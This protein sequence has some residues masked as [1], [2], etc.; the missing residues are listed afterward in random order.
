MERL[1]KG[2]R[3]TYVPIYGTA[4]AWT[5][6]ANGSF[7]GVV[8]GAWLFIVLFLILSIAIVPILSLAAF[9]IYR[10]HSFSAI[11]ALP[12]ACFGGLFYLFIDQIFF[13]ETIEI[14]ASHV[15][16]RRK[17]LLTRTL[18]WTEPRTH[19]LGV[20]KDFYFTSKGVPKHVIY[21]VHKQ[22]DSKNV[23]LSFIG[24]AF[25]ALPELESKA[26]R[27]QIKA[28]KVLQTP[29]LD[30]LRQPMTPPEQLEIGGTLHEDGGGT[31]D[32][33]EV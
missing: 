31:I 2:K 5:R 24:Q 30:D 27:L 8:K 11:E 6:G 7:T 9:L 3:L 13:K 23:L 26:L 12:F 32:L 33:R 1:P 25:G 16:Y 14:N 18:T 10:L 20:K 19:Y 29:M 17:K 22:D 28:A 21:L 15:I 4:P